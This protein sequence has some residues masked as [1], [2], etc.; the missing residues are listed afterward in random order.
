[1]SLFERD[2]IKRLVQQLARFLALI[3]KAREERQL[4]VGIQLVQDA[5]REV[6][7]VPYEML[8]RVDERSAALLLGDPRKRGIYAQL[9]RAEA[10]LRRDLGEAA[11]ELEARARA[12][13]AA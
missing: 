13:E 2:Y 9:L 1:M 5:Y 12:F 6:L 8:A 3:A 10:E 11:D 4:H 7:G